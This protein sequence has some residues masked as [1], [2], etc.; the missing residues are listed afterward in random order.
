M[1]IHVPAVVGNTFSVKGYKE[2]NRNVEQLVAASV[3]A[4]IIPNWKHEA[5]GLEYSAV[6]KILTIQT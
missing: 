4:G 1:R 5:E 6:G 2:G 3:Y